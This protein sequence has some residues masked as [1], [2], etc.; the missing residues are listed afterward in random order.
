MDRLHLDPSSQSQQPR[1]E[2][3]EKRERS[4]RRGPLKFPQGGV[5]GVAMAPVLEQVEDALSIAR[6]IERRLDTMQ[7]QLNELEAELDDP[8]MFPLARLGQSPHDTRPL[9]A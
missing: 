5:Y 8:Y 7:T 3:A 9:A 6:A 4:P 1:S 2:R